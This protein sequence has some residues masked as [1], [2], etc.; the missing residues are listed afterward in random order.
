MEQVNF[1]LEAAASWQDWASTAATESVEAARAHAHGLREVVFDVGAAAAVYLL[2]GRD[3]E[4]FHWCLEWMDSTTEFQ[5]KLLREFSL[6]L[7][8]NVA[9]VLVAW[10]V[11]GPRIAERSVWCATTVLT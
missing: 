8:G 1:M 10:K 7:L 3:S 6:I 2:G 9:L 11:Y 4:V 5:A